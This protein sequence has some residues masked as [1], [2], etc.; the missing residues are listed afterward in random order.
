MSKMKKIIIAITALIFLVFAC[1]CGAWLVHYNVNIKP[2]LSNEKL[3][4][5]G[6]EGQWEVYSYDDGNAAYTVSAPSFLKFS[7]NLSVITSINYNEN[8][9]PTNN[10]TIGFC[11]SPRLFSNQI[12]KYWFTVYD[13]SDAEDPNVPPT[14]YDIYTT[15]AL[16]LIDESESGKFEEYY[17]PLKEF[18]D[19]VKDFFGEDTFK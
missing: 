13:Y 11:Y 3:V 15:G 10:Y 9:E 14:A 7:G 4:Y 6:N 12:N 16:E 18:Y 2:M 17:E 8:W 5:Q 19:E 1:I